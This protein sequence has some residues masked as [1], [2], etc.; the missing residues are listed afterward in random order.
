MNEMELLGELAQETPLPGPA[1]LDAARARLVAAITPIRPHT[2]R[3]PPRPPRPSPA[4]PRP[5]G[6]PAAACG[7]RA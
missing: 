5:A 1:E 3:P 6:R 7:S 4:R 2:P